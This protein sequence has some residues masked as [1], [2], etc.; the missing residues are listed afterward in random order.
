MRALKYL[1]FAAGGLVVLLVLALVGVGLFVDPNDYKDRIATAVQQSTGRSLSLP[2]KLKLSVFPWIKVQ[3]GEASLGNPPGFGDQPFLTLQRATLSARLLPLLHGKLEVGRIEIDG[4]D[5][6]LKQ[7]AQGKG[8]WE[9]WSAQSPQSGEQSSGT[10]LELAGAAITG[11]VSFE[12]MAAEQLNIKVGRIAPGVPAAVEISTQLITAAGAKPLPL[13]ARFKLKLDLEKQQ[14]QL[15]DLT[16]AGEVQPEGAPKPLD[17]QLAMPAANIDLAAQ[18][19]A[20]ATFKAQVGA[21]GLSGSIAGTKLVDAP[22]LTG[23]FDLQQV[24][25]RTLMQEFGASPPVTRNKAVLAAFQAQGNY[26]WEAGVARLSDLKLKLDES[27]LT[28]KFTYNTGDGGMDFA[29][30]LDK[31]NLDHYMPPPVDPKHAAAAAAAAEP[32]ELPVDFLKSLHAKGTFNV[33]EIRVDGVQFTQF[34]AGIDA[35]DSVANLTPLKAQLYG[36]QYNGELSIDTRQA[37]PRLTMSHNLSGVDMVP[38][39]Q[40]YANS[41][42]ISGKGNLEAKLSA[43]GHSDEA[44]LQTLAGTINMNVADGAVEGM[45]IWFAINEA[46]SLLHKLHL[47]SAANTKRTSFDTFRASANVENGVATTRDLMIASRT[48]QISGGGSSNLVSQTVD[49]EIKVAVLKAPAGSDEGAVQ[50][51]RASIPVKIT[52]PLSDPKIRPELGGLVKFE[53][54]G[55]LKDKVKGLFH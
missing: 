28:G 35:H 34:S 41:K 42:R 54:A 5:L 24:A 39:L 11:R 53:A 43:R 7:N 55:E 25:P 6:K 46:R 51:E 17:W 1:G 26:A 44:L 3:T 29:L 13:S 19:L 33:G 23:Q 14:Y 8:N 20:E 47:A 37:E 30:S 40:D 9:D 2:G 27:A 36:G 45:D 52:G 10:S 18:T 16:L 31:I 15:A 49:Y 22:V 48:L 4:L 21:A 12:A 50:L 38:F 32:V